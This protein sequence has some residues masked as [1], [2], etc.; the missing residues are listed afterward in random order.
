MVALP[1]RLCLS[2]AVM[3]PPYVQE[4]DGGSVTSNFGVIC[5][6][7]PVQS[8]ESALVNSFPACV[9]LN[10]SQIANNL[11]TVCEWIMLVLQFLGGASITEEAENR[12]SGEFN[13]LSTRG[14][15]V[16]SGTVLWDICFE[17]SA[18]FSSICRCKEELFD[19]RLETIRMSSFNVS[20]P[21]RVPK[22]M[23]FW[24]NVTLVL[25]RFWAILL[26]CCLSTSKEVSL[27]THC[28]L[29]IRHDVTHH[30][31]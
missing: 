12:N 9:L 23:L 10:A 2:S 11:P 1:R 3:P 15:Y 30:H 31:G 13:L 27:V 17:I 7:D 24:L 20:S 29:R 18:L 14:E 5:V 28:C 21:S 16:Q 4:L 6:L 19:S 25:V 26:L 8:P 22:A